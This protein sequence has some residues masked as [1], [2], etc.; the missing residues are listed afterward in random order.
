MDT[1]LELMGDQVTLEDVMSLLKGLTKEMADQKT[2]IGTLVK[3]VEDQKK[4]I[5]ELRVEL[6]ASIK[7]TR[8]I[9]EHTI[10]MSEKLNQDKT[11]DL[12]EEKLRTYAEATKR[13][14]MEFI[15]AKEEER[16]LLEEEHKN[17]HARLNNCKVSG[18]GE[19][20][21]EDT[22]KV[23]TSFFQSHLRVHEP[24]IL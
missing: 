12:M 22:K 2:H 13:S 1:C 5:H 9:A 6:A 7:V 23:V 18:L 17:Q 3:V 14:H 19:E 24:T 16:R 11:M 21:K 15:Q 8:V 4:E 10:G 20:E